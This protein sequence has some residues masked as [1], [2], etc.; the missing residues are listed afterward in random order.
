MNIQLPVPHDLRETIARVGLRALDRERSRELARSEVSDLVV[1]G[2]GRLRLPRSVGGF[3]LDWVASTEILLELAAQD[4]NIPQVLRGHFAVQED[5][6]WRADAESD[7]APEARDLVRRWLARIAA[8]ELV[9]NA[10]TEPG[11]GGFHQSGTVV[12][13]STDGHVVNGVKYYTTGAIFADW[14]DVTARDAAG[15]ELAVLMR[16]DQPGVEID[17]DWDGFGQRTT[18]SGTARLSDAVV[19]EAELRGLNDRFPYQTALY[20]HFLLIVLAGVSEAAARDAAALLHERSRTFSHANTRTPR[21]DPQ[22]LQ[23]VGEIDAVAALARAQVLATAASLDAAFAAR[24][25]TEDAQI[26]AANAVELATG[27]AQVALHRPVLEALTRIFDVLGASGVSQSRSLDRH[28]RNARTVTSHNPWVYK[29]RIA[30]DH[31][32]NGTAPVRL[33]SVGEPDAAQTPSAEVPPGAPEKV[34]PGA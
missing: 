18:G 15:H 2:I 19:E 20:Q 4:S 22:L 10:W 1:A 16:R 8:G 5:L 11:K 25:S 33:W 13:E 29:A 7:A 24:S 27:R 26:E 28:W 3:G 17:D 14:L 12:S 9:G 23:A 30:G 32:V 34:T 21:T 31:R 6:L